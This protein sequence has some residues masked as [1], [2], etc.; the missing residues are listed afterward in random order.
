MNPNRPAWWGLMGRQGVKASQGISRLRRKAHCDVQESLCAEVG[1]V[2]DDF[3]S[4]PDLLFR[5]LSSES[6][7]EARHR[8]KAPNNNGQVKQ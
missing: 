5:E 3:L 6:C 8:C 4:N 7:L 1:L 2:W